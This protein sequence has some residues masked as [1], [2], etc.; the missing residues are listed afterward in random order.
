MGKKPIRSPETT[1]S[2]KVCHVVRLRILGGPSDMPK[3]LEVEMPLVDE[4]IELRSDVAWLKKL[5]GV[6]VG[7]GSILGLAAVVIAIFKL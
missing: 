3:E 2:P 5:I 4:I 1:I 6:N 7:I